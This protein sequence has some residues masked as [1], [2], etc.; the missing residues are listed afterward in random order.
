MRTWACSLGVDLTWPTGGPFVAPAVER[1]RFLMARRPGPR[2]IWDSCYLF[3]SSSP[4]LG[5]FA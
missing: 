2:Q 1:F 5:L 3:E 4:N